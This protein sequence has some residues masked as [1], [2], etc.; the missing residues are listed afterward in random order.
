MRIVLFVGVWMLGTF[1]YAQNTTSQA[2][3]SIDSLLLDNATQSVS[4]AKMRDGFRKII[5]LVGNT[6]PETPEKYGAKGDGITNDY[7]AFAAWMAANNSGTVRIPPKTYKI[8][9][10][11]IISKGGNGTSKLDIDATGAKIVSDNPETIPVLHIVQTKRLTVKGLTVD[12]LVDFDGMWYSDFQNCQFL[13][14]VKFGFTNS[15]TF[16]E[17][18]WNSWTR[19]DFREIWIHTGTE[20]DNTEFNAN[21]FYRCNIWKGAYAFRVFGNQLLQGF[22]FYNCDIS[23]QTISQLYVD[24]P[25]K[26]GS[27]FF[28]GGYWD[29]EKG[30]PID[31]KGIVIN[32]QGVITPNSANASSFTLKTGSQQNA[33][34]YSGVRNGSRLATS[35]VNLLK[36]GD[37]QFG[38]A[39]IYN[40]GLTMALMKGAGMFGKYLNCTSNNL[41]YVD[42]ESIAAPFSGTYSVTVIGR[43][44]NNTTLV[45]VLVKNNVEILYSPVHL[46]DG[47]ITD[48]SFVVSSANVE[49]TQGDVLKVRF[50]TQEGKANSFDVAYCGLTYGKMG[51]LYAPQHPSVNVSGSADPTGVGLKTT[52]SQTEVM[53]TATNIFSLPMTNYFRISAELTC[54]GSDQTYP[55]GATY[56]KHIITANRQ[57]GSIASTLLLIT[58]T[59]SGDIAAAPSITVL[60]TGNGVLQ[61]KA[62]ATDGAIQLKCKLEGQY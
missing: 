48:D 13:K 11:L 8:N 20:A 30:M 23:Y 29:S 47:S 57:E 31:T 49:L 34:V 7:V 60:D 56:S 33:D 12:G 17:F 32:A 21:A 35:Y 9:G 19:C 25:L 38:T 46:R 40:S 39:N 4:P 36:N 16:D 53:G 44:N 10:T 52:Y 3:I 2:Q 6:T 37:F 42:F 41:K 18:Y 1:A 14:E 24:Q 54:F 51:V 5:N 15:S 26:D 50:Y 58:S 27:L 43:N 28:F 59:K 62:T 22:Y 61:I 45:P 55:D